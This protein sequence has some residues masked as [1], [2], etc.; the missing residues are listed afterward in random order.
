MPCSQFVFFLELVVSLGCVSHLLYSCDPFFVVSH[1]AAR[2][3]CSAVMFHD[4]A[5]SACVVRV[6]G[7]YA[8][9]FL[10]VKVYQ[11]AV[12]CPFI[13][14]CVSGMVTVT[15]CALIHVYI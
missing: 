11:V 1:G 3:Q 13:L 2:V 5:Q 8:V 12:I 14:A 15:P 9:V 7:Q 10:R 4:I 6:S